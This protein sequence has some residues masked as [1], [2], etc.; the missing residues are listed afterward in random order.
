MKLAKEKLCQNIGRKFYMKEN[1]QEKSLVQV[2]ENSML[3]KIKVFF[4]NLFYKK[5]EAT[6]EVI[7]DEN[8]NVKMERENQRN[9]FIE[10]IRNIENEE[11]KLLKLQEQYRNGE[12][13]E[14]DLTNEQVNAL[15]KLYD[16][17]IERLEKSNAMKRQK[18]LE[19]RKKITN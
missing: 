13:K 17:Q 18:I 6:N 14:E 16:R 19:Y 2:N 15:C 11:T 5:A 12:V 9:A 10:N 8:V 3:Y 7:A 1:T 4:K